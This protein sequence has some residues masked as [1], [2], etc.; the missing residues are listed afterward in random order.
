MF[1]LSSFLVVFVLAGLCFGASSEDDSSSGNEASPG[2]GGTGEAPGA[3]APS[4]NGDPSV[5]DSADGGSQEDKK[6]NGA[7]NG[8]ENHT[9][10]YSLPD[11]YR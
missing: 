10:G 5:A 9:L 3:G 4:G 8:K 6:Q 2:G 1:K 7:S 11:F